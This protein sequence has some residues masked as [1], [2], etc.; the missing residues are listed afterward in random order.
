MNRK[1]ALR[2]SLLSLLLLAGCSSKR[3][4]KLNPPPPP[5]PSQESAASAEQSAK[6]PVERRPERPSDS[7]VLYTE[8]GT[9]SWYGPPYNKRR[10]AN[11]EIYDMNAMTAAH[12]TLPLNSLVRV[13][14][15]ANGKSALVRI[16][17]RGPFIGNRI[18][19]L[20]LAAAK[21]LDV[22]R[23]GT[24]KVRL[25][26]LESPA[27]IEAGGRWAV[28]IGAFHDAALAAKMKWQLLRRYHSA[29]VLQFTGPTGEWVR[30][31]VPQDDKSKAQE[32]ARNTETPEGGI[33]LVRL[34]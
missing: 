6:P 24:A 17:D 30:V 11:G 21:E 22:W 27:P 7:R 5:E 14:N 9:A 26:V 29:N 15:I 4:A 18:L 16:T 3:Q 31:R 12:K 23:P 20:S 1:L 34:D 25:E 13:T 28:Q 10:G 8:I 2:C 33:F 19:D 32:I